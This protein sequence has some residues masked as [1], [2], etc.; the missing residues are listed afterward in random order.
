ML[1]A[2]YRKESSMSGEK[3]FDR[4]A[5]EHA[6]AELGRRAFAAGRRLL[7]VSKDA[8]SRPRM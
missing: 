3:N 1:K 8:L 6:L 2:H 4:L 7:F 5:L